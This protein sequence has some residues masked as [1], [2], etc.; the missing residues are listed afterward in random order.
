MGLVDYNRIQLADGADGEESVFGRLR[1]LV[2]WPP[3]NRRTCPIW[4]LSMAMPSSPVWGGLTILQAPSSRA[5]V[6]RQRIRGIF[7]LVYSVVKRTVYIKHLAA[8]HC[9]HCKVD[10]RVCHKLLGVGNAEPIH[11]ARRRGYSAVAKSR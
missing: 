9:R 7:L 10:C 11:P 3:S 1:F 8:Y 6:S 2:N 4:S 5:K